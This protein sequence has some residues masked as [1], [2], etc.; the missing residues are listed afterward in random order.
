LTPFRLWELGAG[1][2][3]AIHLDDAKPTLPPVFGIVGLAAIGLATVTYTSTTPFPGAAAALPVLG[4]VLVIAARPTGL[5]GRLLSWRPVRLTGTISY[6]W[7]LWHWPLLAIV[8]TVHVG[9]RDLVRDLLIVCIAY[10]P[11]Y[12]STRYIETPIRRR[13]LAVVGTDARSLVSGAA[14][15]ALVFVGAVGLIGQGQ[16]EFVKLVP[17]SR[18]CMQPWTTDQQRR[19]EPCVLSRGNGGSV[20]LLGDSQANHWSPV[21][22]EWARKNDR[23]AIDLSYT[24]CNVLAA[25]YAVD[26]GTYASDCRAHA[27]GVPRQIEAAV[28]AGKP[29]GVVVSVRWSHASHLNESTRERDMNEALRAMERLGVRVLILGVTPNFEHAV[30]SCVAR[31]DPRTCNVARSKHDADRRP[32]DEMFARTVRDRAGVRYLDPTPVYC[33]GAWCHPT[34]H[35]ALLFF[36][37]NHLTPAGAGLAETELDPH[38]DWLAGRRN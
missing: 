10:V 37:H 31:R 4:A 2:L 11:A 17:A 30:P 34:R 28:A 23:Y 8:R 7:Y 16:D 36:D 21:L 12:L 27:A 24:S 1:A 26:A 22:A 32:V 18:E 14:L 38:F 6:A 25:A 33:D 35:G 20:F 29:V 13:G 15:I 3:L 9:E 19:S 5:A